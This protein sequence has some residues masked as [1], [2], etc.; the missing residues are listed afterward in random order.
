MHD[1]ASFG[2]KKLSRGSPLQ[3]YFPGFDDHNFGVGSRQG[4]KK[5][6]PDFKIHLNIN[7]PQIMTSGGAKATHLGGN[8]STRG[9][10]SSGVPLTI[11]FFQ[12]L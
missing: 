8:Q 4:G 3:L 9:C 11:V 12:D 1:G 2:K 6:P 7:R 5:T 10:G